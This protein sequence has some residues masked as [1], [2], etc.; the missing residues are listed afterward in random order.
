MR[1]SIRESDRAKAVDVAGNGG[2]I[3]LMVLSGFWTP[4]PFSWVMFG[5]AVALAAWWGY[6]LLVAMKTEPTGNR[7]SK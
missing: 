4:A 7:R 2:V 5:I 6:T 3:L 1:D